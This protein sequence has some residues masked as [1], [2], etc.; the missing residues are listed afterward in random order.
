MFRSVFLVF[1]RWL[2]YLKIN[3]YLN[4]TLVYLAGVHNVTSVN[5]NCLNP[6]ETVL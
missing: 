2:I 1:L 4:L 6:F 3:D 5:G